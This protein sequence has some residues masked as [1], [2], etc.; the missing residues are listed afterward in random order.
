M[1]FCIPALPS[2]CIRTAE[3]SYLDRPYLTH[4]KDEL[5]LQALQAFS[6]EK[7]EEEDAYNALKAQL[8]Q[9]TAASEQRRLQ[10]L[11][12]EDEV[13]DKKPS[14]LLRRMQQLLGDAAGPNPDNK[15]LHELFLQ[16]LPSQVRMVLASAG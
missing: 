11:F 14:Q 15:F 7:E 5:L 8:I 9:R 10:Q 13:R 3:E 4:R 6:K 1:S 16:R 12:T 2:E